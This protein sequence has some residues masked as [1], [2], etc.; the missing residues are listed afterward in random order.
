MSEVYALRSQAADR[1]AAAEMELR[2]GAG[3]LNQ[4]LCDSALPLWAAAG[5]DTSTGGFV[6]NIGNNGAAD[7]V[8]RRL[9]VHARQI[10]AF[11][12]AQ[13]LG[14]QGPWRS[15]IGAAANYLSSE[16]L[17]SD[18]AYRARI[19]AFG[20][21]LDDH[22][23]MYDQAFVLLALFTLHAADSDP[24]AAESGAL[25]LVTQHLPRE[26]LLAGGYREP[27]ADHT[28]QSNPQM[29]LFEAAL[30]WE[31]RSTSPVWSQLADDL[32]SL[33]L[34]RLFNP[35]TAAIHEFYSEGWEL[36]GGPEGRLISPGHQFEWAWLL[37]RWG[38]SRQRVEACRVAEQLFDTGL[39]GID[40]RR[41]AVVTH[42]LDD[43]SDHSG[44]ARLWAQTEWLKAA[45]IMAARRNERRA[46]YLEQAVDALAAMMSYFSVPTCGAWH[47]KIGPDGAFLD[48]PAPASSLYH[49]VCA[50][51]ELLTE[52]GRFDP[53]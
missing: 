52:V 6:E 8:L 19:S 25:R 35:K 1:V 33:A 9:L 48:E 15:H 30:A 51:L 23:W 4:W 17:R 5:F 26:S 38:R 22:A 2:Q 47:D 14:W 44:H 29:H 10:Y 13:A 53:S 12:H 46:A 40:S 50:T 45:L 20:V 42:Q 7:P 24:V 3:K 18:G 43:F 27:G 16:F 28:H 21:I 49:I 34:G 39:K 41:G 36:L 37:E 31:T 32:A 11:G